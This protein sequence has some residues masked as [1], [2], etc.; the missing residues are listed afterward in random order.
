MSAAAARLLVEPL[1]QLKNATDHAKA[2]AAT[3]EYERV[4]QGTLHF[5]FADRGLVKEGYA[6]DLTVFQ[7][8]AN[9]IIPARHGTVPH[10]AMAESGIRWVAR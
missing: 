10:Q 3:Q 8:T 2:E 1:G 9:Y 4:Q 5:R 7:R 6:A